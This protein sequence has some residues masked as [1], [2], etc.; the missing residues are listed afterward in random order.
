MR[1]ALI[2]VVIG[3]LLASCSANP[4][5]QSSND[6]LTKACRDDVFEATREVTAKAL[7]VSEA[8]AAALP[9]LIELTLTGA[10]RTGTMLF[11]G[12]DDRPVFSG[13]PKDLR[14]LTRPLE[15]A[16]DEIRIATRAHIRQLESV[17]SA[18]D[19]CLAAAREA[20]D[21]CLEQAATEI[22]ASVGEIIRL[23]RHRLA[24]DGRDL[25]QVRGEIETTS[26]KIEQANVGL[27]T[28]LAALER[29]FAGL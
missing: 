3:L 19:A 27:S 22:A 18:A 2:G 20:D 9:Q 23:A 1:S 6:E 17:R 24:I 8:Y 4:Q 29:C 12:I 26:H 25:Q 13:V 11:K 21:Q 10:I 15:G 5:V 28:G 14:R 7:A 16:F